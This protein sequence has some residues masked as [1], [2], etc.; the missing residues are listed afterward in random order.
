[1]SDSRQEVPPDVG[2]P[3]SVLGTSFRRHLLA[4]PLWAVR[5]AIDG[6]RTGP[7]ILL[8][9]AV[10]GCLWGLHRRANRLAE[11]SEADRATFG[12]GDRWTK[13]FY[14]PEALAVA[15]IL[16]DLWHAFLAFKG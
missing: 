8:S 6:L 5:I 13:A 14:L 1:M 9:F 3:A 2:A 16:R 12:E 11:Q 7:G 4:L 10:D 15:L